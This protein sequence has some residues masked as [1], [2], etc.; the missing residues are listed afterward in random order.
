VLAASVGALTAIVTA[1]G[2]GTT[3]IEGQGAFD[4][5]GACEE[6]PSMFTMQITGDLVGCWYTHGWD[7]VQDTASGVYAERGTERFI[8]CLANGTTCGTFDTE[9]KFTAK[10]ADDGSEIHGRCEHPI[11]FGTGDFAGITGRVDFKDDVENG[12]V[13]Y[14]GHI[15]LPNAAPLYDPRQLEDGTLSSAAGCK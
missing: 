15:S 8:G 2:A 7:V 6:I 11:T 4:A 1:F 5:A 12:V 13:Y 3:Q 10:Y 14:R 9:Y